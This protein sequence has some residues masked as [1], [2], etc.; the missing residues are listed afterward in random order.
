[1]NYIALMCSEIFFL[2][3]DLAKERKVPLVEGWAKMER[4]WSEGSPEP[5]EREQRFGA[6]SGTK[7]Q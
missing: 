3:F 7:D 6:N 4:N 2:N 1:M 5:M